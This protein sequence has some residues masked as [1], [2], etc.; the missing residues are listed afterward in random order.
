[1]LCIKIGF[2]LQIFC[3]TLNRFWTC[4][5]VSSLIQMPNNLIFLLVKLAFLVRLFE[6]TPD[7]QNQI[8]TLQIYQKYLHHIQCSLY[9]LQKRNLFACIGTD[10]FRLCK[11]KY[12]SI[13]CRINQ[14][15]TIT[16]DQISRLLILE[17]TTT[18]SKY[19]Y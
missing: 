4:V 14:S 1:M 9:F 16:K 6:C 2:M 17:S 13:N 19:K 12:G 5:K 7:N 3:H 10:Q 8:F 18:K 15:Y 11:R